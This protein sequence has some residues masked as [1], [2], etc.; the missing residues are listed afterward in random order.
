[1]TK[2]M[3]NELNTFGDELATN[4]GMKVDTDC[5]PDSQGRTRWKTSFGNKTGMGLLFTIQTM[6][7]EKVK[8]LER[9]RA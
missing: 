2:E 4:L 7:A 6:V 5:S 9:K 8:V 3:E 1:M